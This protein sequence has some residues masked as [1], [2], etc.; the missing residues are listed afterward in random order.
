[1]KSRDSII[2][3]V[4][5]A[6]VSMCLCACDVLFENFDNVTAPALPNG[7]ISEHV[8]VASVDWVT[9]TDL[10]DSAPNSAFADSFNSMDTRLITPQFL[11]PAGGARFSF[12]NFY[13]V[14]TNWDGC[15]L[16]AS[17]NGD[18]FADILAL[19]GNFVTGGY[20]V[21][22]LINATVLGTRPAWSG[23]SLSFI[24][25]VVN[26]P[27]AANNQLVQLRWR[28]VT[29]PSVSMVGWN[30]DSLARVGVDMATTVST[31]A[32]AAIV[33]QPFTYTVTV[34]NTGDETVD[35]NLLLTPLPSGFELSSS[36]VSQGTLSFTESNRVIN[37]NIGQVTA[38]S[39]AILTLNGSFP[40]NAVQAT[41]LLVSSP[42]QFAR[43]YIAL[44]AL[45]G[46]AISSTS[47]VLIPVDDGV[48][49]IRDGCTALTAGSATAV[50]GNIALLKAGACPFDLQALN[51]QNA[52]AIGAVIYKTS[53][54]GPLSMGGTGQNITIPVLSIGSPEGVNLAKAAEVPV[55]AIGGSLQVTL[56]SVNE[57]SAFVPNVFGGSVADPNY[58]NNAA[59]SLVPVGFD[60]DGDGIIDSLDNCPAV[61]NSDNA[62]TD[63]DGVGDLCDFTD[64]LRSKIALALSQLG[65]IAL[66]DSSSSKFKSQKKKRAA[67]KKLK[68][69][70]ALIVQNSASSISVLTGVNLQSLAN[71]AKKGVSALLKA[72]DASL[73]KTKRKVA[74]KALQN[75]QAGLA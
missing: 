11:Q 58:I 30:I 38:G 18:A 72:N 50:V 10:S 27:P 16:E 49:D 2:R 65:K 33:N 4:L 52:G 7:W 48:G 17:I 37:Y 44:P 6:L 5:I 54:G 71:S 67:L 1:M 21:N 60:T 69:E 45:F 3:L 8:G 41:T 15:V 63:S 23:N 62:D 24:S 26:L 25:S 31:S 43:E 12:Q 19:G 53:S 55:A 74:K 35:N 34:T 59:L 32:S 40:T 57:N 73:L 20:N 66:V 36:A 28:I 61:A 29:D 64:I 70:I 75:L 22:A 9:T 68:N 14:E 51:A 42:F 47:S 13:N 39:E 46:A 56:K